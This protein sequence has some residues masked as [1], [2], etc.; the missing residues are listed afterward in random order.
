ME[1]LSQLLT[2]LL[3]ITAMKK[4][5]ELP[6]VMRLARWLVLIYATGYVVHCFAEWFERYF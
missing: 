6:W 2:E 1:I 4:D 5:H 3:G